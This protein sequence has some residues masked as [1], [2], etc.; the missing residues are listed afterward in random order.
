MDFSRPRFSHPKLWCQNCHENICPPNLGFAAKLQTSSA[1]QG[2]CQKKPNFHL[3]KDW[4]KT[5]H[6]K[7]NFIDIDFTND[8]FLMFLKNYNIL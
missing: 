6:C 1:F 8:H 5:F 7:Y 4:Y 3:S 2:E